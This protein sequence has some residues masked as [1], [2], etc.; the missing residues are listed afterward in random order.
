MNDKKPNF[1]KITKRANTAMI[2]FPMHIIAVGFDEDDS[3]A[4]ETIHII[5]RAKNSIELIFNTRE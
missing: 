2:L 1:I 3:V 4:Q 5:P